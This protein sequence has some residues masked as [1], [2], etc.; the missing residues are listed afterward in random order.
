MITPDDAMVERGCVAMV[1][2]KGWAWF[3]KHH[4]RVVAGERAKVRTILV[5]ALNP[6][7]RTYEVPPQPEN[8]TAQKMP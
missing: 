3:L 7:P 8:I 4:P 5:A 6:P 2:A 1:G